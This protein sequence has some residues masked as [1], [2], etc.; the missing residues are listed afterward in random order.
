MELR[1]KTDIEAFLDRPGEARGSLIHGPDLGLVRAR[2]ARLAAAATER[3]DDPFDV[4]RLTETDLATAPGRL[5]EELAAFSLLG[6]RRLVRLRLMGERG[7]GEAIAAEALRCHLA[8]ELNPA[9]LLIIE[10]PALRNGA[11]LR[12]LAEASPL[13]AAIACYPDEP[14]DLARL[15]AAKLA[16][17]RVGLSAEAMRR[18]LARLPGEHALAAAEIERLALF[19]GP[20]SGRTADV[21]D[22]GDFFGVEPESSLAEAAYHAFGGRAAA[23]FSELRRAEREGEVGGAAVRAISLHLGRLRRAAEARKAGQS[24]AEIIKSLQVFWKSRD[25]FTRQTRAW[26]I[27]DLD[28]VHAQ[29]FAAEEA[30]RRTGAP[31]SL[32]AERLSFSIAARAQRL[33]L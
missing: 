21:S 12:T 22:L 13:A 19:L 11:P 20:G 2:G 1:K 8:G 26:A 17:D 31:G 9:C 4:A 5:E 14:R 33:G 15:A 24:S 27:P 23:V 28:S 29:T 10:A 30:C 3:P 32:I 6:G 25:E 7:P 18:F 16:E